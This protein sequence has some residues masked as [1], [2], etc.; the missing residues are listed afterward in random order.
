IKFTWQSV[1]LKINHKRYGREQD[2]NMALNNGV[3]I[4]CIK[5]KPVRNMPFRKLAIGQ[6][7]DYL[8]SILQSLLGVMAWKNNDVK[9]VIYQECV[10]RWYMAE[11]VNDWN[12]F[13]Y[14]PFVCVYYSFV[15]LF[16]SNMI[17]LLLWF[18]S[19]MIFLL[20]K[21]HR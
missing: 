5:E 7:K 21:T 4:I 2:T 20:L 15:V 8:L 18:E 14:I 9:L 17:F 3:I 6:G 1:E 12:I 13:G 10:G 19:N 11:V 16:E